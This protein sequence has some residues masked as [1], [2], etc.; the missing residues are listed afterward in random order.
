MNEKAVTLMSGVINPDY[1]P[2]ALIAR[3]DPGIGAVSRTV[4]SRGAADTAD[5]GDRADSEGAAGARVDTSP[6]MTD[7]DE[8]RGGALPTMSRR[9]GVR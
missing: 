5:H 2:T 4:C 8:L 6:V 3:R 7:A 1:S 9:R